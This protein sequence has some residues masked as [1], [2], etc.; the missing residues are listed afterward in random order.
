MT[1]S[2]GSRRRSTGL[3]SVLYSLAGRLLTAQS[4]LNRRDR[5]QASRP[6]ALRTDS[7]EMAL[8]Q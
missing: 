6:F 4:L 2:T 3:S 8:G 7:R 5:Y 1:R